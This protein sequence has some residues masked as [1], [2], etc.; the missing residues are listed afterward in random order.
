VSQKPLDFGENICVGDVGMSSHNIRRHILIG[1]K[2]ANT[3]YVALAEDDALYPEDHFNVL[4]CKR[5]DK[6]YYN[7]KVYVLSVFNKSL[8]RKGS[9]YTGAIIA[10]KYY[11]INVLKGMIKYRRGWIDDP[12]RSHPT[13]RLKLATFRSYGHGTFKTANSIITV[14]HVSS[15]HPSMH[16]VRRSIDELPGWGSA[17]ELLSELQR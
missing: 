10:N 5:D 15:M 8:A 12:N 3:D 6:M 13:R 17:K 16:N 9:L 4:N 1:A 7:K 2:N 11:L 14:D